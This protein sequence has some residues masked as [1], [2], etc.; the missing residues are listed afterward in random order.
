MTYDELREEV[1]KSGGVLT[2]SMGVLRDAHG[3]GK[4]G[5]NVRANISKELRRRGLG[6][7]PEDLPVYQHEAVRIWLMGSPAGDLI[8]AVFDTGTATDQTIREAVESDA[9]DVLDKVREL[10]CA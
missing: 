3:A 9:S 10:V 7:S 5:V 4:L 6:H 8:E 2:V 1:E